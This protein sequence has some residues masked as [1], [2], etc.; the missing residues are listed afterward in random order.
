MM[1]KIVIGLVAHVDAGKTTLSEAML[2]LT[3]CIRK[4][5]RVD[6]GDTYLDYNA[7]E[8]ERGITIFSKQ[9]TLS[10]QDMQITLLDTP[11]HVDFSAEMER[12]L[13]VLDYAVVIISGID[14]I[15]NHTKTIF[16]LLEHY[17]I[18]TF[19]FVNKMDM[20]QADAMSLKVSLQKFDSRLIDFTSLNEETY[21]NLALVSDELLDE[22]M[23]T[24]IISST[25]I[26]SLIQQRKVFPYVF[27]SA[28]KMR[29]VEE[30]MNLLQIYTIDKDYPETLSARVYKI[31]QDEQGQRLTHVK[32]T[33]GT[34]QVKDMIVDEKVDQIRIYN[35]NK[36][37]VVKSVEAGDICALKG[38]TKLQAG[39]GIGEESIIQPLMNAYMTYHILLPKDCERHVMVQRLL[40]L[41]DE[42]PELHIQYVQETGELTV[43]L[44]GEIQIDVLK[45][46]IKERY[47]VDIELDQGQVLF[48]ETIA[49]TV[50]GVGHFEP[51]RHYAEV[52]LLLEPLPRGSGLQFNTIMK[53]DDLDKHWQR[54]VL[55]HLQEKEHKGVLTGSSITDMKISLVNGKAHLKHT[56][57]GDFREA[58]YRAVRQGLKKAKSLLLEPYYQYRL[59]LPHDYMSKAVFDL[60][61][62]HATLEIT[63]QDNLS[64]ILGKAP[65]RFMKNYQSQVVHYTKGQ[66]QLYCT[67]VGYE[68]A[69]DVDKIIDEIGYDS[70]KDMHNP[71]GSIFCKHGAGFYV[72]YDEVTDYM[73]LPTYLKK[74][75]NHQEAFIRFSHSDDDLEAIFEKTYGPVKRRL[76][77]NFS[78]EKKENI[79][80]NTVKQLPEC[81]L[82]DGYN[83]IY[84]WP[85]LKD[86]AKDNLDVARTRLI[87]ILGNYQGYKQCTLIIVFDAYKVKGNVG[88]IEQIH[89]VHVV[90][91][92]EAQTADMY[93]ERTTHQLSQNYRVIVATSDALEQTIVIGQG[94]RRIS[95]RELLLEVEF[96]TKNQKEEFDRKQKKSRNYLL[97]DV[98]NYKK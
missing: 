96:L 49:E 22:Y 25:K 93:I 2:Y 52:H 58:T 61:Q 82:V 66:G 19:L 70:E 69:K 35:G 28:L 73:H 48:K 41:S 39:E 23:Q 98:K 78:Y 95:S 43:Q 44:M 83:V 94:A 92:K 79:H 72:P 29:G 67:L 7:Q 40:Q 50:E 88:S 56:E 4:H 64:V 18:P 38:I 57:G 85:E 97:E 63:Q 54:L 34:L 59:E 75:T 1:K 32:I 5:G 20:N 33:G 13:Q 8:K 47:Q 84:A 15:Q 55:T 89:N 6:H 46:L 62:M 60:E 11:G 71:T 53:E 21:E 90:Y 91:T 10:Y 14:G 26:V 36:Y 42:E 65:V 24:Q 81:L 31:S 9:A 86:I 16:D 12:T 87:D 45:H 68:E 80:S 37:E 74:T 51:L 76:S 3:G 77:D 17:H 27:G 30:L